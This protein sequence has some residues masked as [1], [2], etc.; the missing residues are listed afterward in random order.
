MSIIRTNPQL[1]L[2]PWAA[3]SLLQ[4][5]IRRGEASLAQQAMASL[6]RHRGSGVWRRLASIAVEDVGIA[7]PELVWEVVRLATDKKARIALGPIPDRLRELV[8]RLAA[9][10]K[11]RSAD[12]VY[13]GATK[14]ETAL[15]DR[16]NFDGLSFA[17]KLSIATGTFEPLPRRAVAA[18][19]ACTVSE[20]SRLVVDP[21]AARKFAGQFGQAP[22]ALLKAATVLSGQSSHPF[23]LMLLLVRSQYDFTGGAS[24]Y[25]TPPLPHTEYVNGIPLYTFDKHTAVGKRAIAKFVKENAG[26]QKVLRQHVPEPQWVAIGAMAAFYADAAPVSHRLEWESGPL[27]AFTGFNADMTAAG[28]PMAVAPSVLN[29]VRKNLAHLNQLRRMVL[30]KGGRSH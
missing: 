11:D 20:N 5:A 1:H 12:Y 17:E 9:A 24:G 14:L 26:L 16:G 8:S 22:D 10:P 21:E 25:S 7:D 19:S 6:H 3:S 13:C 28:C 30:I 18:L 4:K 29:C 23:G 15:E 27:L 2:D